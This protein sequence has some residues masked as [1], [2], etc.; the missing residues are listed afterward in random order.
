MAVEKLQ[1]YALS[2]D[3]ATQEELNSTINSINSISSDILDG[4]SGVINEKLSTIAD[5]VEEETQKLDELSGKVDSGG[6]SIDDYISAITINGTTKTPIDKVVD[7]GTISSYVSDLSTIYASVSAVEELSSTLGDILSA[8][9]EINGTG[10]S[11]EQYSGYIPTSD[12]LYYNVSKDGTSISRQIQGPPLSWFQ[13][14]TDTTTTYSD[15][16]AFK[17]SF[18]GNAV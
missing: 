18:D 7:L 5:L 1:D 16:G 4:L 17:F 2:T 8:L 15:N 6:S 11:E 9:Q 13:T 12:P 10:E 14:N 3:L